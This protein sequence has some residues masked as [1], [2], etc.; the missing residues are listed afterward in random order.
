MFKRFA[1]VLVALSAA[2]ALADATVT[3]WEDLRTAIGTAQSGDTI[4]LAKGDYTVA[5]AGV[6]IPAGHSAEQ[7]RFGSDYR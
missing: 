5:T 7:R 4:T 3:T 2:T 6:T 1:S